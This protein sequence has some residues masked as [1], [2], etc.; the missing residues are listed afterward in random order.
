MSDPVWGNRF[1]WCSLAAGFLAAI[2]GRLYDS[3][4]V[5]QLAY[6]FFETGAFQDR[7]P[8]RSTLSSFQGKDT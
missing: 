6:E 5:R 7:V 4:Y 8:S 2:E 1:H 3:R